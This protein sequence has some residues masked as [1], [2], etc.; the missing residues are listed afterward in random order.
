MAKYTQVDIESEIKSESSYGDITKVEEA[1][2]G[3][4]LRIG[5]MF[6]AALFGAGVVANSGSAVL[7]SKEPGESWA[8]G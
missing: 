8:I 3:R 4:R 1:I 2:R 5:A 6:A 7:E